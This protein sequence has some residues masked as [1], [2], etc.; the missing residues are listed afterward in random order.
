MKKEKGVTMKTMKP[1]YTT[2]RVADL[3][4]HPRNPRKHGEAELNLGPKIALRARNVIS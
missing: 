2:A 3:R 1:V 4:P